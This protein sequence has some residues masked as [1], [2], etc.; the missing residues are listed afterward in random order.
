MSAFVS[1]RLDAMNPPQHFTGVRHTFWTRY[2]H[3]ASLTLLIYDHLI[4]FDEEYELVWK[5]AKAKSWPRWIFIAARYACP[6]ALLVNTFALFDPKSDQF[7]QGWLLF[8]G[9]SGYLFFA[10][11]QVIS[12]M[13]IWAMYRSRTVLLAMSVLVLISLVAMGLLEGFGYA[14]VKAT[15]QPVPGLHVCGPGTAHNL[16]HYV[17]AFW[18]PPLIIEGVSVALVSHKALLYFRGEVPNNWAG[19]RLMHS[20]LKYSVFYFA[21][22]LSLYLGNLYIWDRLPTNTFELLIPLTYALPSIA[23]NRMLLSLRSVFY[24]EHNLLPGLNDIDL[25]EVHHERGVTVRVHNPLQEFESFFGEKR[26]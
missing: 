6:L 24:S 3:V 26:L 8:H 2:V 22:V 7:C 4:T 17:F 20:L 25:M 23:G 12:Q 21:V 16:P 18:L 1:L 9:W 19:T 15:S 5:G 13:R 14:N 10:G 11:V